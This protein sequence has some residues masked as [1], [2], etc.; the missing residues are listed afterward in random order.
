[1]R[2]HQRSHLYRD[3]R[4]PLGTQGRNLELVECLLAV[5]ASIDPTHK[6]LNI[7]LL[8]QDMFES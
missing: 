6:Y 2:L 7:H 8:S 4:Q 5:Y 1:M 3:T